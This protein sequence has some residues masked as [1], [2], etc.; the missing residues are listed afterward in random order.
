MT[1]AHLERPI[2]IGRFDRSVKKYWLLIHVFVLLCTVFGALIL[3][4]SIPLVLYLSQRRLDAMSVELFERKLVVRSGL[5]FRMEKTIPLEKITDVSMSHGPLMRFFGL[6]QLSFE[7]AGQSGPGALVSLVGIVSAA[8]FREAILAQKD[9]V[10]DSQTNA[11]ST[12]STSAVGSDFA[13]LTASVH[14]IEA[15]VATL[16]EQRK[17]SA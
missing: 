13:E 4:I 2:R 12:E 11:A 5:L 17:P 3:P 1:S 10:V 7:T 14:R 6:K 16:V 9:R 8:A 15:L